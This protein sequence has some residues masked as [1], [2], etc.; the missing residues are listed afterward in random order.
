M[1]FNDTGV[2]Y[3]DGA[4]PSAVSPDHGDDADQQDAASDDQEAA[5]SDDQEAAA[6]DDQ[7][8]A[9]SDDNDAAANQQDDG[10][11]AIAPTGSASADAPALEYAV[12]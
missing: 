12:L 1:Q 3:N 6:S 2:Q 11:N 5:T 4:E 8:A 10:V 9:A 7:D